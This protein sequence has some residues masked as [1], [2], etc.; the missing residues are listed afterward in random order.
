MPEVEALKE[1]CKVAAY[2]GFLSSTAP[3]NDMAW[4]T[5]DAFF[6]V[7]YGRELGIP[8]MTALKTIYVVDGKPSCSGQALLALMRRAGVEVEIPD[9]STVTDKATIRIRRPGGEWREYTYTEQMAKDAGLIGKGTWGKY[10]REMLIWR[11]VST[12]NKYECSDITGGLYTIEELSPQTVL[13]ADGAPVGEIV[14]TREPANVSPFPPP[15]DEPA[16]HAEQPSASVSGAG[17]RRQES[18]SA[19]TYWSDD[20][21][22][23]TAFYASAKDRFTMTHATVDEALERFEALNLADWRAQRTWAIAALIADHCENSAER[24]DNYSMK[25]V[26]EFGEAAA[27]DLAN[28]ARQVATAALN[29]EFEAI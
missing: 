23:L 16:V 1:I 27:E 24:I 11:A 5:A 8:A 18:Q 28:K 6:V 12:A 19:A 14:V 25:L 2:S 26:A 9:P 17:V 7:M 22:K 13:D 21:V 4:R 15:Q 29:A 3:R 20:E 10:K